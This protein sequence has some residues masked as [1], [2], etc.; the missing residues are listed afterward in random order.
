MA[1]ESE[2]SWKDEEYQSGEHRTLGGLYWRF[3]R[4]LDSLD[5]E[6]AERLILSIDLQYCDIGLCMAVGSIWFLYTHQDLDKATQLIKRIVS[7]G[8]H[9]FTKV[10][11]QTYFLALCILATLNCTISFSDTKSG[12][13]E[14]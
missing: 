6:L 13:I 10:I 2:G 7:N 5:W 11:C 3:Q 14:R 1:E 9:D 12:M 8:A 4:A